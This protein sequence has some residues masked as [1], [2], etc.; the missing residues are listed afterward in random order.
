MKLIENELPIR[1]RNVSSEL[2]EGSSMTSAIK[3]EILSICA[4]FAFMTAVLAVVW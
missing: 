2:L 1:T 3:V 4:A